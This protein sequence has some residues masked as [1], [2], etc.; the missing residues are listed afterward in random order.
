ME[1]SGSTHRRRPF[2]CPRLG[3]W[4]FVLSGLATIVAVSGSPP[5]D[6]EA[7]PEEGRPFGQVACDD[8][9]SPVWSLA[10]SPDGTKLA[11]ATV[12]GE[13]WIKDLV[14]RRRELVQ[15]GEMGGSP[16]VAFSPVGS[17]FAIGGAGS[18]VRVVDTPSGEDREPIRTAG[19]QLARIVGFS[20]DGRYAA[21]GGFGPVVT[22]W[23]WS[24]RLRLGV[25][26]GHHGS[27]TALAFSPDGATL[28][29]GDTAGQV[30]LVDVSSRKI[31]AS[32]PAHPPGMGVTALAFSAD[33]TLLATASYLE[34]TV[35]LW[36]AADGASRGELP[37]ADSGVRALAFSPGGALMA[38]ARGDG[39]AVL[40]DIAGARAMATVRANDR[41]L[42]SLAFSADGR[43]LATGGIDGCVRLWDLD[44]VLDQGI[45]SRDR[46]ARSD[47]S[48]PAGS[49]GARNLDE[50][51]P[52]RR[53]RH[54]PPRA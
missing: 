36:S 3:G 13:V 1:K 40:W 21:T 54:A 2:R 16:S 14:G 31:R 37:R 22:V 4:L 53:R 6:H 25:V 52:C 43:T 32:V 42:Q 35:R 44:Q 27:V 39:A 49:P 48:G 30:R 10:F 20:R 5:G 9:Q 23:D 26:D 24:R 11:S 45:A 28:A 15:R 50:D 34:C 18:D 47:G 7:R 33:G 51:P 12:S 46:E 19:P 29:T 8:Q 17:T 41:G 38:L